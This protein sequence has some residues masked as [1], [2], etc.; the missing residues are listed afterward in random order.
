MKTRLVS[1]IATTLLLT[2]TGCP[3]EPAGFPDAAPDPGVTLPALS[4]D[5]PG[6][7]SGAADLSCLGERTRPAPGAEMTFSLPVAPFGA[8]PDARVPGARV[9]IFVDNVPQAGDQCSA[10]GCIEQIS[11]EQGEVTVTVP[12]SAWFAVRALPIAG[13]DP[14]KTFLRTI[15]VNRTPPREGGRQEVVHAISAAVMAA[16]TEQSGV[17]LSP[18]RG[19][20][21]GVALDCQGR[22]MSGGVLR[23]FGQNGE[24]IDASQV[25][26][27]NGQNPPGIDPAQ[28]YGNRDGRYAVVDVAPADAARV[29]LWGVPDGEAE[30]AL[31]ACEET[32]VQA[33]SLSILVLHPARSDGPAKCGQNPW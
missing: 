6:L 15:D 2:A 10:P 32:G 12:S 19:L 24:E 22:P 28:A 23:F 31:V 21:S 1:I 20:V 7:G 8:P 18:G 17:E 3:D 16:L 11:D 5:I 4:W 30:P 26:Y 9:Q 25:V 33:D 29:E 13:P 27:F 14:G